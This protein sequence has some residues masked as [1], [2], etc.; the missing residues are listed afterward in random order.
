MNILSLT[1][2]RSSIINIRNVK[3]GMLTTDLQ[4]MAGKVNLAVV[5][6]LSTQPKLGGLL[7]LKP[8]KICLLSEIG[9]ES[10]DQRSRSSQWSVDKT[11]CKPIRPGKAGHNDELS[12]PL[13]VRR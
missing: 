5:A 10:I 9:S 7:L 1:C 4:R 2:L 13:S 12:G 3:L 6:I 11:S 8:D